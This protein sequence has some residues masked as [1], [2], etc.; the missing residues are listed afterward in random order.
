[1]KTLQKYLIEPQTDANFLDQ[2]SK[3]FKTELVNFIYEKFIEKNVVDNNTRSKLKTNISKFIKNEYNTLSLPYF[4]ILESINLCVEVEMSERHQNFYDSK[5]FGERKFSEILE[6][7][8]DFIEPINRF[9]ISEKK[10]SNDLISYVKNYTP[11]FEI[12][13]EILKIEFN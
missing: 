10:F 4:Y 9:A 6:N 7:G 3:E 5:K 1:M 12:D 2:V 11:N 13:G 8:V